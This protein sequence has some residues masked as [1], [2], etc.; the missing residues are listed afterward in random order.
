MSLLRH[1]LPG[2]PGLLRAVAG[3]A[4][5]RPQGSGLLL[6]WHH[7]IALGE[8]GDEAEWVFPESG[9]LA[10]GFE[11]VLELGRHCAALALS[12][13]LTDATALANN[14][15][16]FIGADRISQADLLANLLFLS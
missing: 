10:F 1:A 4:P 13:D 3:A 6:A 5:F 7:S 16:D 8:D 12:N 14:F 9:C 2:V 15:G 11:E